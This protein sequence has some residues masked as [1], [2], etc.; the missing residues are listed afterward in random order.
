MNGT[1]RPRRTSNADVQTLTDE[2]ILAPVWVGKKTGNL[3]KALKIELED[4]VKQITYRK[5]S[6]A[7]YKIPYTSFMSRFRPAN[8]D[9]LWQSLCNVAANMEQDAEN[10]SDL[11]TVIDPDHR[12]DLKRMILYPDCRDEIN[13][14]INRITRASEME[15]IWLLSQIEPKANRCIL[16]FY[17]PPGTGKTLAAVAVAKILEKK[18]MKVDYAEIISKYTGDTAKHIKQVFKIA[19]EAGAALM[20]D[21]ADAL[22][23]K[24]LSFNEASDGSGITS[25]NQNR[26]VLLNQVDEFNGV[27]IM[28]TNFF[29][30]YDEAFL[31]RIARHVEFKLPNVEMRKALF[32]LHLPKLDKVVMSE[33]E[34]DD[35]A[36]KSKDFSGGDICNVVI[37]AITRASMPAKVKDWELNAE[38]LLAEIDSIKT[39]KETHAEGNPKPD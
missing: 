18:L 2:E 7:V 1:Q 30:N 20:F 27:V 4:N 6:G 3:F 14:G 5:A 22:L 17:G 23:S 15:T 12:H 39:A 11:V 33:T 38:D 36:N 26:N 10:V 32:K 16:N 8:E 24:R 28:C 9:D 37:N 35:V 31:R 19:R 29:S 13:I 25:I 21:E 34:W